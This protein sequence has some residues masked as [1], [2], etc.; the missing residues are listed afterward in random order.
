MILLK[1]CS[2]RHKH[3]GCS[4]LQGPPSLAGIS[5]IWPVDTSRLAGSG[6]V[7][8]CPAHGDLQQSKLQAQ[9]QLQQPMPP[10]NEGVAEAQQLQRQDCN[11]KPPM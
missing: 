11:H 5:L 6:L 2:F 10:A 3:R 4:R 1:L 9:Q 8:L 7:R